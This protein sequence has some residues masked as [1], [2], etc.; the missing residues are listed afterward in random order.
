MSLR[1]GDRFVLRR[2]LI[3]THRLRVALDLRV[4]GVAQPESL[5]AQF[6]DEFRL[7]HSLGSVDVANGFEK[8]ER[9]KCVY[10]GEHRTTGDDSG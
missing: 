10:S 2:P 5:V 6:V 1:Q 3:A 7:E 8:A 4:H 9:K